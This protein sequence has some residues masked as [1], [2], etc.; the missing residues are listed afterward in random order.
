MECDAFSFFL[1]AVTLYRKLQAGTY[2]SDGVFDTRLQRASI[3][4]ARVTIS[5]CGLGSVGHG[6]S[7]LFVCWLSKFGRWG[8]ESVRVPQLFFF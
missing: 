5:V 1:D 8:G 3:N 2:A 4:K 6:I 7:S